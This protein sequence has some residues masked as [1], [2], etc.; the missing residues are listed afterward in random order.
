MARMGHSFLG[1]MGILQHIYQGEKVGVGSKQDIS[2]QL[3]EGRG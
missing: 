1:G 2:E 3:G